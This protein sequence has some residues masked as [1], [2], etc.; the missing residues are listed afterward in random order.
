MGEDLRQLLKEKF[1]KRHP[2]EFKGIWTAV[3][4]SILDLLSETYI[5]RN[6][7]GKDRWRLIEFLKVL[8]FHDTNLTELSCCDFL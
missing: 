3:T 7:K 6:E 2:R 8:G 5:D 1:G 4:G